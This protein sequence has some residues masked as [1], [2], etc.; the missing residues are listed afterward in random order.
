VDSTHTFL[1]SKDIL[2]ALQTLLLASLFTGQALAADWQAL[3]DTAPTPADNPTTAAKVELGKMLYM[4]PRCSST[5]TV[6]CNSCH[7]INAFVG[8]YTLDQDRGRL[9]ATGS[10]ADTSMFRVP[11]LRNITDTAP[12][13]HNGP[14]NDL[15]AALRIMAKTQLNRD[16]AAAE[17]D[18]IVAFMTALTGEYPEIIM[19][20]LPATMGTSLVVDQSL[21]FLFTQWWCYAATVCR[22]CHC[23][24]EGRLL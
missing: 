16:L 1:I 13:F 10:E 20:W 2:K 19:P 18:D 3:P 7:N 11:T 9:E 5:G 23:C 15:H 6:S 24:R 21:V 12:Y 14:V 17:V 22:V 8:Q 4:D